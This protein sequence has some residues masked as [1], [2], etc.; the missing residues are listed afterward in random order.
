MTKPKVKKVAPEFF[1]PALRRSADDYERALSAFH[2]LYRYGRSKE[3]PVIAILAV[4][5]GLQKLEQEYGR[6]VQ[7]DIVTGELAPTSLPAPQ[8]LRDG[9]WLC[10][11]TFLTKPRIPGIDGHKRP[12]SFA[13][14]LGKHLQDYSRWY[15]RYQALLED[16]NVDPVQPRKKR[17][18]TERKGRRAYNRIND[19]ID[20]A[21]QFSCTDAKGNALAFV[22]PRDLAPTGRFAEVYVATSPNI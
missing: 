10:L 7:E 11:E 1:Y 6:D 17:G 2:R 21:N 13:Q 14:A 16:A 12:Q 8:W 22:E 20:A 5:K 18:T 4:F 15:L 19:L 3:N 9:I